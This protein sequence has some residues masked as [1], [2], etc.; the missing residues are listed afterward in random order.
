MSSELGRKMMDQVYGEGFSENLPVAATPMLEKTVD[1]LFG[2]I[3]SRPGLSVRDRR[4]LVLGAT[5]ALGRADLIR[6]QVEG[7]LANGELTAEQLREA[8]LHLHYYVGW[9]NG[10]QVHNGVEA[11]LLAHE[12]KEKK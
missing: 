8:V 11:A 9:G 10:T 12:A 2:E 4:L 6:I 1:H 7:A 3:W 5:A